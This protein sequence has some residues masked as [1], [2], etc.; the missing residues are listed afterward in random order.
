MIFGPYTLDINRHI[1]LVVPLSQNDKGN[2]LLFVLYNDSDP[3]ELSGTVLLN[4]RKPSGR[5]FTFPGTYSG[6]AATFTIDE[7]MTAE[8]GQVVCEVVHMSTGGDR[9]G[10]A[11]F[12]LDCERDPMEDG[13]ISETDLSLMNQAI[14]AAG[15]VVAIEQEVQR[16]AAAVDT[17]AEQADLTTLDSLAFKMRGMLPSGDLNDATDFGVY[18]LSSGNTYAHLPDNATS[19]LLIVFRREQSGGY[20]VQMFINSTRMYFR[21]NGGSTW[22]S[23]AVVVNN[24]S[25]TVTA[26]VITTGWSVW[27]RGNVGILTLNSAL[28]AAGTYSNSDVLLTVSPAPV[29]TV[30]ACFDLGGTEFVLKLTSSGALTFNQASVTLS[31]QKYLLGNLTYPIA[32]TV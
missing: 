23:W 10:S 14:A 15:Q 32:T 27:R 2:Q 31:A 18:Q 12:I 30:R 4:G 6:N 11:N 28:L 13:I 26:G 24:A 19:A 21:L 7:Q 8:A 17:K 20:V 9:K 16:V 1:P 25:V 22:G 29:G 5:V 3:Y